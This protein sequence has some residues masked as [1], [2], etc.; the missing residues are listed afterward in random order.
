MLVGLTYFFA[1]WRVVAG[2][3]SPH[4]FACPTKIVHLQSN[5]MDAFLGDCGGYGM[6]GQWPLPTSNASDGRSHW[7]PAGP[8]AFPTLRLFAFTAGGLMALM[9]WG[10][11]LISPLIDHSPIMSLTALV[12]ESQPIVPSKSARLAILI[13]SNER[14]SRL[15]TFLVHIKQRKLT[16]W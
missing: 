14:W 1:T 7:W 3:L 4:N 11:S 8:T 13:I 5:S 16:V 12:R 10:Y 9:T 15:G 6:E 2:A